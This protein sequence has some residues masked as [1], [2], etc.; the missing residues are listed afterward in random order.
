MS[1]EPVNLKKNPIKEEEGEEE[2]NMVMC[3]CCNEAIY[4]DKETVY[5]LSKGK[6]EMDVVSVGV[7][8][9]MTLCVY[10]FEDTWRELRNDGWEC[11]DFSQQSEA[12]QIMNEA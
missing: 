2:E 10:C 7:Q 12:E 8:R 1:T 6:K 11:D 4:C 9:N 3:F 5:S